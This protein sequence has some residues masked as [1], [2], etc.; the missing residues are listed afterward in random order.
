MMHEQTARCSN[1]SFFEAEWYNVVFVDSEEFKLYID[2]ES[3]TVKNEKPK[4]TG[5]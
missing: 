3:E 2:N 4:E 1:P 5:R